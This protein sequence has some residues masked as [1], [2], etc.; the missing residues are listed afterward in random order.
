MRQSRGN[1]P[2]SQAIIPDISIVAPV[3]N[4]TALT[5]RALVERVLAALETIVQSYEI[6]LVDDGS[7]NDAW[8]TICALSR[9]NPAV[10]GIRLARNFGQHA[11]IAAGLDHAS[12]RWVVVMDSDLQ[13]RPEVI[14]DLYRKANEGYDVVFINRAARP[15]SLIY[16]SCATIFYEALSFLAGQRF[17]RR[18]GNFSIVRRPVVE[19]FRNVPDR[20]RFYG[21][22]VRW[23][24]FRHSSITVP[25]GERFAGKSV[26]TLRGR[27]RFASHL[28]VSYSTRLLYTAIFLGLTLAVISLAMAIDIAV[29]KIMHPDHMVLGWARVMTAI[30]F[31][32]GVTNVM[33]GLIGIYI[34]RLFEQTKNR[35]V[36]VVAQHA[37]MESSPMGQVEIPPHTTPGTT[38]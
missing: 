17:E 25:H 34:G 30:F 33:L 13:D 26:Y 22:T 9:A 35:P 5:L 12:G 4:E 28:I 21:G 24:G 10:R 38:S 19:A 23:L 31:T 36:Y 18:Q 6:V 14:P 1:S 11:A 15:E 3:Y 2:K 20:D 7:R 37:G 29:D 32:A 16:R 27:L 8:D